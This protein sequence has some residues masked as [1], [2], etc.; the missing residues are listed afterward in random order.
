MKKYAVFAV[1][2][3]TGCSAANPAKDISVTN[4]ADATCNT[5]VD[6]YDTAFLDISMK[7]VPLG[8]P[9]DI[10]GVLPPRVT[11]VEGWHIIS[12][13]PEFGGLSGLDS[14]PSSE[15]LAVS[16]KGYFITLDPVGKKRATIIPLRDARG[17]SLIGKTRGDAEGLALKDGIAYVSFERRHRV[18]S[19]DLKACGITANGQPFAGSPEDV[20]N[21]KLGANDGAE[22]LDITADGRIRAGYETVIEGQAPLVIFQDDGTVSDPVDYVSVE[23]DFKLVG[24]D[25]GYF[26][27]RAYDRNAGNRN[28][29][30]GPD[31]EFKLAPPLNVDNFEGIAVQKMSNGRTRIYLVSDDNYSARQRT[32]LYVFEIRD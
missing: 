2:C 22:A 30:R 27:F 24:A 16:D 29:I 28:I 8:N 18:L 26:L 9:S 10:A 20:L 5:E 14:F 7:S 3:L 25:E 15:L 1:C 19:Y 12:T 17:K 11:F 13:N 6:R 23:R 31:I 4:L 21:N 32:L